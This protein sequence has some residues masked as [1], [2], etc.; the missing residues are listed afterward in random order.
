MSPRSSLFF[1]VGLLAGPGCGSGASVPA[2]PT[3]ANV[4]PILRGECNSCHGW[5]AGDMANP[6]YPFR[7][8]FYDVTAAVCGDAALAMDPTVTLAG[9]SASSIQISADVVPQGGTQWPRMPPQ[10]SPALP[11]FEVQTLK[12]WAGQPVKG[13]P[14]TTNR[15]PT[16]EVSQLPF[17]AKGQLAFTAII[18]DPDGDSVIG[19]IEA[20]G[21]AFPMNRPGSFAVNFDA[22]QWPPGPV[23]VKA[24]LCDGWVSATYDIGPVQIQN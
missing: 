17:L 14:P 12:L 18:D 9:S 5:T 24:V 7:F 21:F 1:L 16:V 2:N 22:S 15:P 11:D 10:P 3:W 19:V 23:D 20:N 8:D 13:P 6:A 4:E